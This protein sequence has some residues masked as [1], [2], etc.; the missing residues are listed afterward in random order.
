MEPD[1]TKSESGSA[2]NHYGTIIFTLSLILT[3]IYYKVMTYL[4][5][6]KITRSNDG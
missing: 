4:K 3:F 1:V 5:Y 6:D 2:I